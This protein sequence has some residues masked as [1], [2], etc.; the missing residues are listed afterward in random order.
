MPEF[1]ALVN[2][3]GLTERTEQRARFNEFILE[4]AYS[5]Q[6]IMRDL[7]GITRIASAKGM[8]NAG[9]E[10]FNSRLEVFQEAIELR[11][12]GLKLNPTVAL[13]PNYLSEFKKAISEYFAS[14][15]GVK[16][17][18]IVPTSEV[19]R[20]I[21]RYY[22]KV[23]EWESKN[24]LK[25]GAFKEMVRAY[26][27]HGKEGIK[28]IKYNSASANE[29]MFRVLMES[30]RLESQGKTRMINYFDDIFRLHLESFRG[31]SMQKKFSFIRQR[32]ELQTRFIATQ[33]EL[34]GLLG[35]TQL[36]GVNKKAITEIV[37]SKNTGQIQKIVEQLQRI[38]TINRNQ[39]AE[40]ARLIGLLK[41]TSGITH[42][43]EG[44]ETFRQVLPAL[45]KLKGTS[46]EQ[47]Q[48]LVLQLQTR[49]PR[50]K[51][52]VEIFQKMGR[53]KALVYGDVANI[54]KDLAEA[55]E[56]KTISE[57]TVTA[58]IT[59][60]LEEIFS[61]D[62]FRDNCINPNKIGYHV[63][64]FTLDP[65]EAFIGFYED[66]YTGFSLMHLLKKGAERVL[67]VE[68]P[69]TNASNLTAGMR[70]SAEGLGL[71]IAELAK[72]KGV[73]N[74]SVIYSWRNPNKT[75]L[76]PFES[77][78]SDKYYDVFGKMV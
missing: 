21:F 73:K 57:S 7:F 39:I 14:A 28:R 30:D 78:H 20:E 56:Q 26:V 24:K 65:Q 50:L 40:K 51:E 70:T 66:G 23:A 60:N 58:K 8:N 53:E 38:K 41:L 19:I 42:L 47:Q 35:E 27:E 69:Y 72:Q 22:P 32:Q 76:E 68:E 67:Y 29:P 64:G 25:K 77:I 59:H 48:R 12:A 55:K 11:E 34:I 75:G 61:S 43:E 6:E 13:K 54:F 45:M 5:S 49:F 18:K 63:V 36:V 17:M 52:F 74:L 33:K 71:K 3:V 44:F 62:K 10:E 9:A 46:H 2:F 15:F 4:H 37:A 16:E 1:R 31:H